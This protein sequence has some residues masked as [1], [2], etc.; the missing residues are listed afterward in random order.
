MNNF[1]ETNGITYPDLVTSG[2]HCSQG[3][4]AIASRRR[5]NRNLM[6][7]RLLQPLP[8]ETSRQGHAS[9]ELHVVQVRQLDCALGVNHRRLFY[10]L[11]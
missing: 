3:V 9:L 2:Q 1:K 4:H 8:A 11:S 6:D 10:H 7:L 5:H